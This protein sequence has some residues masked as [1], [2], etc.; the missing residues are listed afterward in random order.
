MKAA[1][2]VD[3]V[4]SFMHKAIVTGLLGVSAWGL[5]FVGQGCT[6][7]YLRHYKPKLAVKDESEKAA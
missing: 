7:I 2:L 5:V 6:D 1:V 3:R 4:S